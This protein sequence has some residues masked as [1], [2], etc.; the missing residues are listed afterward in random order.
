MPGKT[1]LGFEAYYNSSS[2]A[3]KNKCVDFSKDL[4]PV[5]L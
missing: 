1:I 3:P 5:I 4:L 2:F